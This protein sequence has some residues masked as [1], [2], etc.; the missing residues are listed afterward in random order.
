MLLNKRTLSMNGID[1]EDEYTDWVILNL[2]WSVS[3]N[4]ITLSSGKKFVINNN[5]FDD[6]YPNPQKVLHFKKES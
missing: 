6:I 2:K 5:K 1:W 3:E 4:V